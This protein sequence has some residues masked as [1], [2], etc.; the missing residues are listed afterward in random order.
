MFRDMPPTRTACFATPLHRKIPLPLPFY[1]EF[2]GGVILVFHVFLEILNPLYLEK[3]FFRFNDMSYQ[4]LLPFS[5]KHFS[6]S[7]YPAKRKVVILKTISR[8]SKQYRGLLPFSTNIYHIPDTSPYL[9]PMPTF[10]CATVLISCL[11][12]EKGENMS[13]DLNT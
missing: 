7:S 5:T 2:L 3:L 4:S 6:Y 11:T 8:S 12:L 1:G 13:M 9:S 10:R